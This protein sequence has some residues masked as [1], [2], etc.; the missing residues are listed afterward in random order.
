MPIGYFLLLFLAVICG[1][2]N[3]I[4]CFKGQD[5]ELLGLFEGLV[6]GL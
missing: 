6:W 3:R 4:A 2:E 5:W 1:T